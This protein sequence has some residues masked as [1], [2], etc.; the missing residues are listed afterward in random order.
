MVIKSEEDILNLITNDSWMMNIL[1]TAQ[2]L[3]LPDWWICA[4]FVRTKVWDTL[5]GYSNKTNLPDIDVVYF[6]ASNTDEQFEKHLES[7]L[8]GK[9]PAEP[10]SV[11]NQARMH[12]INGEEPYTST[13]DAVS[14]FP[15]TATSIA[16]KLN[17]KN[18]LILAA[19][20]GIKDLLSLQIKPTPP[21]KEKG[22]L[23]SIYEKRV[24]EKQ[25]DKK[26]PKVKVQGI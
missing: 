9:A 14:R 2:T 7:K 20:W 26:W 12:I 5:H 1:K 25:W 10:W 11:K 3:H 17:E 8:K 18:E 19:P 13:I 6:D 15:E 23:S 22:A 21:F 24:H 4:G 16:L